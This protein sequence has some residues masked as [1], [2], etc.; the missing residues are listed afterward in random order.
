M[1]KFLHDAVDATKAIAIPK[2]FSK[3]TRA[4]KTET[5]IL[6]LCIQ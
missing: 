1:S 6:S 4:K 5:N 2:V 3:N